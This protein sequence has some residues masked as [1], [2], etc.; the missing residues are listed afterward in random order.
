MKCSVHWSRVFVGTAGSSRRGRCIADGF[1]VLSFFI[2]ILWQ[3]WLCFLP[4]SPEML[5]APSEQFEH[6]VMFY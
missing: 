4:H 1:V 2:F 6:L 3:R 5:P